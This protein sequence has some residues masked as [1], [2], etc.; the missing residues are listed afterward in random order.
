M[1]NQTADDIHELFS[2]A[3]FKA[4]A[5]SMTRATG[6]SWQ[7]AA[8]PDAESTTEESEQVRIRFTLS[9]SLT[10]EFLVEFRR[11]EAAMLASKLLRKPAEQFGTAQSK[12]L[13]KLING[14]MSEFRS[15]LAAVY[16]TFTTEVSLA[17]ASASAPASEPE[18]ARANLVRVT[19]ADDVSNSISMLMYL[20]PV[21][22]EV[23]ILR[24]K[25]DGAPAGNVKPVKRVAGN[26]MTAIPEQVNLKLVLDVELNVTLR[27]GQRQLTL[28]EVLDLTSGSVIEL[29]RQVEEPVEL[30]LEGKVIARGEAVVIDGNYGL[31]VTE[32]SQRISSPIVG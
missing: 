12:A 29:D 17:S 8:V 6:S 18:A 15:A 22:S 23:L 16:G 5:G 19:A 7:I 24:S 11:T 3:F 20:N 30:L 28:R 27:F 2:G 10:G 26:A 31:R 21:L 25:A 4:F 9:G 14:G 32:V 13:L 1:T